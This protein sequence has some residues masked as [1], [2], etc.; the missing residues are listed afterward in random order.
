MANWNK[1]NTEFYTLLNDITDVDWENWMTLRDARKA[2]RR[3][4]LTLR[5]KMQ[6]E[7]LL[8]DSIK[9]TQSYINI[10]STDIVANS[11]INFKITRVAIEN[12]G[13]NN[14]ALAA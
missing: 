5:A 3:M 2:M 8:L 13:E 10:F 4:E 9:G 11:H 1:L 14:N 7:K 6:E 12:V